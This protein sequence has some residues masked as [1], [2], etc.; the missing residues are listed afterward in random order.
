MSP[1]NRIRTLDGWRGI[2]ILLVMMDHAALGSRFGDQ[3]WAHLGYFGVDIF[4]VLSGYII[5]ARMLE[6]RDKSCTISLP[7]FYQRRAFRILPLVLTYLGTL[8]V[9]SFFR[10]MDLSPSQALSSLFFFRNYQVAGDPAGITTGH[11]WSLSVEEHFYLI[12]P[13]LLF[14]FDSRRAL[15]IA[16]CG[17]LGCGL[18]RIYDCA[19][20]NGPIGRLLPGVDTGLRMIRTDARLD[21]L[22]IGCALAI[23]LSSSKVRD[24]VLK[25]FPKETPL[26]CGALIFFNMQWSLGYPTLTNYVL[27]AVGIAST[28]TVKEGLAYKWLNLRPV[29]WIGTISFSLYVWQ[30]LFLV[31]TSVLYPV[32]VLNV[33]PYSFVSLFAVATGSYYF[34]EM[35]M[36]RFG[37]RLARASTPAVSAALV[38]TAGEG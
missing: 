1:M 38:A 19:H 25:N 35:P 33:F 5:T 17:A 9:M 4:F 34:I 26:V 27:I 36:Q 29:V 6:E 11:F 24:F 18:W 21:G 10:N 3:S 30:E 31:H 13:L 2:A 8:C 12:W 16:L 20:P 14:R 7:R 23:L 32:G 37:K 15:W 22:L 28:L